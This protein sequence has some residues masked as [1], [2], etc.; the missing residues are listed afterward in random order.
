MVRHGYDTLKVLYRYSILCA[1]LTPSPTPTIVINVNITST[2][3]NS[4]GGVLNLTCSALIVGHSGQPTIT[5]LYGN[6]QVVAVTGGEA[7]RVTMSPV[8]VN[9]NGHY[10]RSLLLNPLVYSDA[11][12]FTCRVM[13]GGVTKIET[14]SVTVNGM[15]IFNVDISVEP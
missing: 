2:G 10:S 14:I 3:S 1:G 15:Y 11:G 13:S 4:A 8:T 9:T 12:L 6:S 5:W 7:A